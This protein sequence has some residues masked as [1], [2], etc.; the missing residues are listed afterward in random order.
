MVHND[1]TNKGKGRKV[2]KLNCR[3]RIESAVI[4]DKRC[5]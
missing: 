4:D 3:D 5:S 1:I 2:D